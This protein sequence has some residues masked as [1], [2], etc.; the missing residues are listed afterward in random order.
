MNDQAAYAPEEFNLSWTP[1]K[2]YSVTTEGTNEF[3]SN[4]SLTATN[5]K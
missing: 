4:L 2:G 5:P 1:V 3:W